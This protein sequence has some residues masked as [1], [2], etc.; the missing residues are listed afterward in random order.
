MRLT[1]TRLGGII[2]LTPKDKKMRRIAAVLFVLVMAAGCASRSSAV[3]FAPV[4]DQKAG[5]LEGFMDGYHMAHPDQPYVQSTRE[6]T[7]SN[8]YYGGWSDGYRVGRR[9]VLQRE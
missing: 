2:V 6:S 3:R 4:P 1:C 5:Y 7:R 8:D 9:E